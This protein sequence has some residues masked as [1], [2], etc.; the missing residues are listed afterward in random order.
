[1]Q[2]IHYGYP[3]IVTSNS[4]SCRHYRAKLA[5]LRPDFHCQHIGPSGGT[6]CIDKPLSDHYQ[7]ALF[8]DS[9]E[10]RLFN[11]IKIF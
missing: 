8:P 7:T 1:M 5:V 3:D 6:R 4:T 9:V 2:S 10:N 11:P